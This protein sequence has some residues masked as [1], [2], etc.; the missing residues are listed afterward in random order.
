LVGQA[1][2]DSSHFRDEKNGGDR[3]EDH[4]SDDCADVQVPAPLPPLDF[5]KPK[6]GN[7]QPES[8]VQV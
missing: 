4:G 6:L 3:H 8:F 1:K 2:C 7:I 5:G